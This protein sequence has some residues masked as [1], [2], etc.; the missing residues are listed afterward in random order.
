VICFLVDHSKAVTKHYLAA[1]NSC[2]DGYWDDVLREESYYENQVD[3][4]TEPMRPKGREV[5]EFD[6][7]CVNYDDKLALYKELK[8]SYGDMSKASKQID[9]AEE[10]FEDTD[11]EVMGVTVLER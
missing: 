8:T 4:T 9:R 2:K 11:W 3:P 10:F 5:G 1:A 6:V 7:L